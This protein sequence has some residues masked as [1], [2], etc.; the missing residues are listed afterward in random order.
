MK[1]LL[2]YLLITLL[3]WS[4]AVIANDVS[5]RQQTLSDNSALQLSI[6][7]PRDKSQNSL[8]VLSHG[9]FGSASDMSLTAKSIAA[10]GITVISVQHSSDR[11]FGSAQ[12]KFAIVNRADELIRASDWAVEN[13]GVSADHIGVLGYSQGGLSVVIAAGVTPDRFL[14]QAHC[15]KNRANDRGYCGYAPFWHRFLEKIGLANLDDD[16]DDNFEKGRDFRAF[17]AVAVVAPVAAIVPEQEFRDISGDI[18]IFSFGADRT[19]APE[20]HADYL[21]RA[22][23][24]REHTYKRYPNAGHGGLFS[25]DREQINQ[26]IADFFA[27]NL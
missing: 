17:S 24:E 1:K 20:Y 8:V 23:G 13:L 6:W 22:L 7:E 26:D 25:A 4:S 5:F 18:G 9:L 10:R 15:Q 11:L 27:E 3:S 2:S 12:H 21:H 19:L 16:K 14:A